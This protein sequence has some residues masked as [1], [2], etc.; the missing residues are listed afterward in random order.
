[1]KRLA[2]LGSTGSIGQSALGVVDLYPERL[3]VTALAARCNSR[4]LAEQARRYRPA[5]VAL[6]ELEAAEAFHRECPDVPVLT[7]ASGLEEVACHPDADIV[8]SAAT[9]A[10]GLVPTYQAIEQGRIIALANKEPMVMAGAL[11]IERSHR[12]GSIIVPVDSEHSALHQCL[13]GSERSEIARLILTASGGPFLN[14]SSEELQDVTIQQALDHPTWSMGPK[15]TIDSA[16]LMNK[17]LEVIEA[18]HFFGIPAD[19]ISVAVHPQSVVHSIVEFVDG[20]MLAQLSITDMRSCLLYAFGYPERWT[21]RLP[22]LDLFTLPELSFCS[23][24]TDRFP[25]LKLAYEALRLGGTCPA[26]LNAANEVAVQ[27]FLDGRLD[28]VD[29]PRVIERTLEEHPPLP[30]NDL[31][32]VLEADRR[33]REKAGNLCLSL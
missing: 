29:I 3:Q 16:T 8:L 11:L 4:L 7:G 24:D 19:R 20:T 17:G 2:I 23:P 12:T 26:A 1:M 28:F 21:S 32:A 33:A 10:A 18:C 22:R 14:H 25:C 30:A 9:G 15:I 31:E 5:L 6:Y 13:R 27:M